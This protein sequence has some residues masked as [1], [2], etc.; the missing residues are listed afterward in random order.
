MKLKTKDI[1]TSAIFAAIISFFSIITLPIGVVPVTLGIFGVLLSA[2]TLKHRG[3]VFAVLVF[4]L[5]GAFG[6]PVFSGFQGG[7]QV[8]TGPTGGYITSYIF[9]AF[10]TGKICEKVGT[11][12][13][14]SFLIKL[15]A[16]FFSLFV[17][18]LFGT[19]QFVF[20]T[21]TSI[22]QAIFLCVVPFIA[23]DIVKCVLAAIL[24]ETLRKSLRL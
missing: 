2:V 7:I 1:T 9:M 5:M 6:I 19:L 20:V 4:I 21:K 10:I 23:F 13:K 8:L 24:G 12:S 22:S 14:K 3:S 18:Y 16:C 15:F 11:Y 17:C